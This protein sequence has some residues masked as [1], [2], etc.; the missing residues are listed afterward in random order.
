[1]GQTPPTGLARVA[2]TAPG[3]RWDSLA[4]PG[5]IVYAER[6]S[7]IGVGL[8]VL[9]ARVG[10]A[11]QRSLSLLGERTFAPRL[12]VFYVASRDRMRALTGTRA[13][14]LT[15]AP[16]HAVVVVAAPTWEPLDTHEVMHAISL[17]L[18]GDPR[19]RAAWGERGT[20]LVEG[21]AAAAED[22]CGAFT[23]RQVVA[24]LVG[25]GGDRLVRMDSLV[26]A[27]RRQD[28]LVAYLQAGTVVAYLL[29]HGGP[30]A[31][32]RVWQGG[33]AAI[34]IEYGRPLA[35]LLPAWRAW[36]ARTPRPPRAPDLGTLGR[37]GCGYAR[38]GWP[39][40]GGRAPAD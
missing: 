3:F 12:R 26:H 39:A 24:A 29:E 28:D 19:E 27:F 36:L 35:G 30:G 17:A 8:P 14:G 7:G 1:M 37:E 21:I 6:G 18:W 25:P 5:A 40:A 13:T 2:L 34:P 11:R 32:K 23:G 38:R 10:A 16:A 9:A 33:P 31:L 4:V 15:D 20:W 22:R